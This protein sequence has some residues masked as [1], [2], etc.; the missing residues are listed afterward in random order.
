MMTNLPIGVLMIL[1]TLC[2]A[3]AI[4]PCSVEAEETPFGDKVQMQDLHSSIE[5]L[6]R[7]VRDLQI[8]TTKETKDFW[9]KLSASSGLISGLLI[10]LIGALATFVYRQRQLASEEARAS[11]EAAVMESQLLATLIPHL[12]SNEAKEKETALLAIAALGNTDLSI[13]LADIYR[14]E[15]AIGALSK[16]ANA[17]DEGTA[18][19]A[20]HMLDEV[21]ARL[22]G[23]VV[24]I[25]VD[26]AHGK[27]TATGFFTSPSQ[28][29]V[30]TSYAIPDDV[31]VVSIRLPDGNRADARLVT[32]DEEIGLAILRVE[33]DMSSV[34]ALKTHEGPVSAM[35]DVLSFVYN[36]HIGFQ[37]VTGRVTGISI[38]NA[39]TGAT[40]RQ[41]I[42]A[43]MNLRP[44]SGG[45][46]V[47]DL[48]GRLVGIV[49]AVDKDSQIAF[50]IP[51]QDCK[52]V[53]DSVM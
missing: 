31:D 16:L 12:K 3:C 5:E 26:G 22:T 19:R 4:L 51:A 37:T 1:R 33:T 43:E 53:L 6:R 11:R 27:V 14:D 47:I 44:G 23:S 8:K 38:G 30:T 42:T 2:F 17:T 15:A 24:G 28:L 48:E 25:G 45:A 46:P 20:R 21:L 32:R 41:Q 7:D 9:D 39:A 18:S 29:I 40:G 36:P 50:L 13:R 49:N 52:A 34:S 10:A 35:M